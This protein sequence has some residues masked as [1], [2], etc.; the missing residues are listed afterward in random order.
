MSWITGASIFA[1]IWPVIKSRVGDE[2]LLKEL[3]L[4][5]LSAF[6]KQDIDSMDLQGLDPVQ[7]EIIRNYYGN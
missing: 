7:D 2:D 4:D 3:G 6:S 5:L 1:E